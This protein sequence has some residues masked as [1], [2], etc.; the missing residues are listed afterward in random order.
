MNDIRSNR[1][2]DR[3]L[4]YFSTTFAMSALYPSEVRTI[5]NIMATLMEFLEISGYLQHKPIT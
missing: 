3:G 2:I 4:K 5:H 1:I